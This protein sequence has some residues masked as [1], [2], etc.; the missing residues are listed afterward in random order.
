MAPHL[1]GATLLPCRKKSRGHR[2]I[3]IGEVLRRLVSKCLAI[4]SEWDAV[5]RF[6]SLQL[7]VG[8]SGG[9]EAIVHTVNNLMTSLPDNKRLTLELDFSNAFNQSSREAMFAEFRQHLPGLSAWMESCYTC[10]PILHLGEATILSCCGGQQGDP[11][12]P[13]GFPLTLHPLVER[14]QPE[15]TSE[16]V[17]L[18]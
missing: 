17:V 4:H 3:A 11:L 5:S 16:R 7:G 8:I 15:A 6:Y 1:C 13:L 14:I 12:G 9:C 18:G 10:Q 2:P